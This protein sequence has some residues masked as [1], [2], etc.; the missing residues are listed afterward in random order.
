MLESTPFKNVDQFKEIFKRSGIENV[1]LTLGKLL[2]AQGKAALIIL[3]VNNTYILDVMQVTSYS[4]IGSVDIMIEGTTGYNIQHDG[5][6]YLLYT[7]YELTPENTTRISR[8]IKTDKNGMVQVYEDKFIEGNMLMAKLFTNNDELL[9]D[10]EDA[11]VYPDMQ[12]LDYHD[13]KLRAE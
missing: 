1:R 2:S 7:K 3:P 8:Y 5:T 11:G 13:G 10:I 9:S 12:R 6:N 4:R